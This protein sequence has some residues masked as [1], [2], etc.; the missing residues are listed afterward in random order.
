MISIPVPHALDPLC[1]LLGEFKSL[2]A[3]TTIALPTV[4]YA[5][6]DG[7]KTEPVERKFADSIGVQGVLESGALVSFTLA[8]TTAATPGY[9]QWVITGEKGSLKFEASGPFLV[10][11]PPTLYQH[12]HGEG[13]EWEIVDF[14][15]TSFGGIGGVY[16][17]FADGEKSYVDFD[18]AVKRHRM[19][20]AVE[21]SATR[22]T[23]ESY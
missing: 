16:A 20:E 3:T 13:K 15:S 11:T 8:S 14:A 19:V 10:M 18:E 1:F 9:L 12:T 7:S 17:A 21:R 23:R 22:G 5:R 6:E 2:S 4:Q